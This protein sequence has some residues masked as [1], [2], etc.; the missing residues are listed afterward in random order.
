[1]IVVMLTIIQDLQVRLG[2]ARARIA[3]LRERL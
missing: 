3:A 1:M 2:E